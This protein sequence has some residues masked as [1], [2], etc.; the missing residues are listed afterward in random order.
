[1]GK[2]FKKKTHILRKVKSSTTKK[3]QKCAAFLSH[4][5]V[6]CC[7]EI[8]IL[9][10]YLIWGRRRQPLVASPIRSLPLKLISSSCSQQPQSPRQLASFSGWAEPT[11]YFA[12]LLLNAEGLIATK[13][14]ATVV[15]QETHK[16]NITILKLPWYC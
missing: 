2:N 4:D 5:L 10:Q 9:D 16:E 6:E 8:Y 3:K 12:I 1:M 7:T 15:L 13:N 11:E 14:K